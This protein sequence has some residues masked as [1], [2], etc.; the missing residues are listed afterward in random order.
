MNQFFLL[1]VAIVGLGFSPHLGSRLLAEVQYALSGK[2]RWQLPLWTAVSLVVV[3]MWAALLAQVFHLYTNY[4][5]AALI[6]LS[7]V[8]LLVAPSISLLFSRKKLPTSHVN[9]ARGGGKSRA[10][11]SSK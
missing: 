1:V 7:F 3:V 6:A 8:L 10:R 2:V 5:W 4:W 9:P 11:N